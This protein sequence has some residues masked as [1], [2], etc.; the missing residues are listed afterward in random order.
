MYAIVLGIPVI[1][2]T[3][4]GEA[5]RIGFKPKIDIFTKKTG[6]FTKKL[7]KALPGKHT[8]LLYDKLSRSDAS[9]LSQ[10]RTGMSRLNTYLVKIVA[11]ENDKCECGAI[12]SI[13]HFLFICPRWKEERRSM[14]RAHK[15]RFGDLSFAVGGY[16]TYTRNGIRLD[17]DLNK[18]KPNMEAVKATIKF[19]RE[20]KRLDYTPLEATASQSSQHTAS[21]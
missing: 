6:K 16:S 4:Y 10:L 12:E 15:D 8:R 3:V 20:T 18:W 9:I 2:S 17:G 19:A 21:Q 13:P 14:R 11:V 7:D 5:N 1:T